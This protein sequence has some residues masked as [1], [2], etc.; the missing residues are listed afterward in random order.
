MSPALPDWS[1]EEIIICPLFGKIIINS[2]FWT[3]ER[4]KRDMQE[5]E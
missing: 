2:R 1:E 5:K 4:E 3:R